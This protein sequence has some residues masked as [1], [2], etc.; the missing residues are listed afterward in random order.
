LITDGDVRRALLQGA[1]LADDVVSHMGRAFTSV[2]PRAS[3][4]DVLDLMQARR[5]L[6]VPVLDD[7][8]RLVGLHL[9]HDVLARKKRASWAVIMAGGRGTRLAPLTDDVPKPMLRVAGRPILERI[10]LHL[11]GAGMARVFLAINYLGHMVEQHFGNGEKF[12]C[13]IDYLR[14]TRPLGTAGAL[15]LFPERPTAPFV[16]MNGDLVTQVD[17]GDMVDQHMESG[18]T[19][20]VGARRY[21][22]TVPFGCL[23]VV[24][25]KIVGLEEKPTL[26]RLIN[27]GIYVLNPDVLASV[28]RDQ[29]VTMPELVGRLLSDGLEVRAHEIVDDWI[30]VG[31]K[32]QLREARGEDM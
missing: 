12:G 1:S 8:G 9:M 3:R 18:A 4:A 15:S 14:E 2:G 21:S 11:A 32:E 30:D 31:Q 27:A 13:R 19:V 20:T 28:P 29:P 7:D 17:I 24:G 6:E 22:L 26:T 10:V 23:D 16:V 5:I 25:Q